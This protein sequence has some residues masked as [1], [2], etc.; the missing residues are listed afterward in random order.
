MSEPPYKLAVHDFTVGIEM[1]PTAVPIPIAITIRH[2]ATGQIVGSIDAEELRAKL[3]TW[4]A[5]IEA[6]E[7]WGKPR[8]EP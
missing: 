1:H 8:G 5:M 3:A 6:Y 7:N 4:D 2:K